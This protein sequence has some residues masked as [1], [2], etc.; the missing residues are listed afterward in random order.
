MPSLYYLIEGEPALSLVKRHIES[1]FAVANVGREIALQFG[2]EYAR[3]S[4]IDGRILSVQFPTGVKHPD[5]TKPDRVDGSCRPKKGTKAEAAFRAHQGHDTAN[6]LIASFYGIPSHLSVSKG[7]EKLK[8]A[9][10]TDV[11]F[12][13]HFLYPTSEGPYALVAPDVRADVRTWVEK[14]YSV[15]PIYYDQDNLPGCRRVLKEE[16]DLVLAQHK[17]WDALQAEVSNG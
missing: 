16:W 11:F 14:G 4:R 10:C 13:C 2:A 9:V 12:P 7:T 1:R 17:L 8:V 3:F 6:D 15:E 5:F